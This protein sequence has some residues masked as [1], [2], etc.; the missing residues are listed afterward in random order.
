MTRPRLTDTHAL[1]N[2]S[3]SCRILHEIATPFVYH[4]FAASRWHSY[5]VIDFLRSISLRPELAALIHRLTIDQ[6]PFTP[7][8]HWFFIEREVRKRGIVLPCEWRPLTDEDDEEEEDDF[9]NDPEQYR[10]SNGIFVHLFLSVASNIK[11]LHLQAYP[12]T[13]Y[14]EFLPPLTKLSSLRR[15]HLD[16]KYD[17]YDLDESDWMFGLWN[18]SDLFQRAPNLESLEVKSCFSSCIG[19][20]LGNLRCL[21]LKDSNFELKLLQALAVECSKLETFIFHSSL[22]IDDIPN[23]LT[24]LCPREVP[25]GLLPCKRTLRHL[26]IQWGSIL[27]DDFQPDDVI[28]SLKD[29]T[30]L[31]TLIIDG[32][33]LFYYDDDDEDFET[34]EDTS[35]IS[36]V[37]LLPASIETVVVDGHHPGLYK[38]ILAF[39]QEVRGGSFSQLKIFKETGFS[40]VFPPHPFRPLMDAMRD[41]RVSFRLDYRSIFK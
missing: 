6:D 19:L 5:E 1:I 32:T 37:S 30:A 13:D 14:G 33:C 18:F 3:Q 11:E 29:F 40:E 27:V 20:A 22:S 17:K 10:L 39:A 8:D 4:E 38:S 12:G 15:L 7:G 16:W 25:Q 21:K 35:L 41:T 31:E 34:L 26:E 24:A 9:L 28:T 36:F 2:L 23:K